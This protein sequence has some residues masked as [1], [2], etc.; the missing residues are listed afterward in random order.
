MWNRKKFIF[1]LA[2]LTLALPQ[3]GSALQSSLSSIPAKDSQQLINIDFN[4]VD[5]RLVIKYLSELTQ[6]NFVIDQ[7]VSGKVSVMSPQ[8]M[9][10]DEAK[11][12]LET[13]LAMHGYTIVEADGVKRVIPS[14]IARQSK[15]QTWV[16]KD[17]PYSDSEAK[18]I[19]QIVP[20]DYANVEKVKEVLIPYVSSAG[21]VASYTPTNTLIISESTANLSKLLSIVRNLDSQIPLPKDDL[22][23]ISLKNAKAKEV[24]S[25]LSSLFEERRRQQASNRSPSDN[26]SPPSIV[27]HEGTNSLVVIA[28]PQDYAIVEKTVNQMDVQKDQ[29]Y[30]EV[31]IVEMTMEKVAEYGLEFAQFGGVVYG[32]EAGFDGVNSFDDPFEGVLSG[33]GLPGKIF[34]GVE[35]STTKGTLSVPKIGLLLKA[36]DDDEDVNVLS[37]PQIMAMDNEEAR[38]LVGSRLAFIKNSQV[39][40]EGGTVATFEFREVGLELKIKP[41]IGENDFVRLEVEQRTEDVIGETFPGAPETAKRETKTVVSVRDNGMIVLGGLIRDEVFKKVRKVPILG[42]IPILKLIFR[43][44]ETSVRKMNLLLFLTPHILRSSERAESFAQKKRQEIETNYSN[45]P[46]EIREIDVSTLPHSAFKFVR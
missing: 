9:S 21:H 44:E 10:V 23:V 35:G 19:T 6:S 22:R 45:S 16:G 31:L 2:V 24:A 38:I 11:K 8:K 42:D 25:V 17:A 41:H 5:I 15:M 12:V 27:A 18:M 13:L 28:S 7:N 46:E 34:G 33:G 30:V 1:F 32:S 4:D 20:L 39:T 43:S 3:T 26:Y 40:A 14:S 29:V 37:T 36:F